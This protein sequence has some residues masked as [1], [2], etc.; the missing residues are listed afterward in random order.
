MHARPNRHGCETDPTPIPP[1]PRV[2]TQRTETPQ[3]H[4]P[5]A[6]LLAFNGMRPERLDAIDFDPKLPE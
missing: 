2:T 3:G 5:W 1:A 4:F 6:D